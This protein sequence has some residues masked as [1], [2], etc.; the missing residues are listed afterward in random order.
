[1][2]SGYSGKPLYSKLDL[3]PGMRCLPINAPEH[4]ME[5]LEGVGDIEFLSGTETVDLVHLF[6]ADRHKLEKKQT[7]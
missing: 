2:P 7:F 4:Y 3:K 1:M 5:L 6:C